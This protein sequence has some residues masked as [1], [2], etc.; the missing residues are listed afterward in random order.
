MPIKPETTNTNLKMDSVKLLNYVRQNRSIEYQNRIPEA[1]QDNLKQI[2]QIFLNEPDL[3]NMF[4]AELINK[5]GL[6]LA[7]SLSFTNRLAMFKAGELELGEFVEEIWV[8]LVSAIHFSPERSE[9]DLFKRYPPDIA[10]AYHKINRQDMYPLS[11]QWSELEKGFNTRSGLADLIRRL[12]ASIITS[13]QVDEFICTKNLMLEAYEQGRLTP[14]A[15]ANSVPTSDTYAKDFIRQV[16]AVSN[17]MMFPSNKYNYA[18]VVNSSDRDEQ[19]L[20]LDSDME[21][22]IDVDVLAAAFNMDRTSFLGHMTVI[23]EFPEDMGNVKAM[24]VDRKWFMIFDKLKTFR[25]VENGAGL[26]WKYMFHVHQIYSVSP[27]ENAVA[28]VTQAGS[29]TGI[30]YAVQNGYSTTV[31][32]ATVTPTI[33]AVQGTGAF[34]GGYELA[35]TA[36]NPTSSDTRVTKFGQV[37]IGEL[38]TATSIT[39]TA[40][41]RGDNAQTADLVFTI[42]Q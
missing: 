18:N 36:G 23:D 25:E 16:K 6:T 34:D 1:T 3:T 19:Y 41:A 12:I 14:I 15:L 37:I 8:G 35:I 40:T 5:I 28:F 4:I 42:N 29:I 24:I 17:K 22:M 13:D 33:A 9:R 10:T 31:D 20:I 7:K 27:F 39:V 38:E 26:Y 30:A 11:I 2:G 32:K 21:A